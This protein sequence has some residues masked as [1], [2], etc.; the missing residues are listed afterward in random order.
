MKDLLI[1]KLGL[2]THHRA[3]YMQ[4]SIW[5]QVYEGYVIRIQLNP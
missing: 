2:E 4:C 3:G 1:Y 5:L